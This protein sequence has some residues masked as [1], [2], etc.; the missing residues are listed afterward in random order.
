MDYAGGYTRF[1]NSDAFSSINHAL[2][3]GYTDQ[4]SRR[5]RLDV[6]ESLGSLT[7]GTGQVANAASSELNTSFTPATRLFD[8]RTYYLQ[9][10]ASATYLQSARTSFTAGV[11]TY[12]QTLKSTG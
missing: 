6:R 3:I 5:L 11:G 8:T 4:L 10:S 7:Y 1:V 2:T 12:L 9:S